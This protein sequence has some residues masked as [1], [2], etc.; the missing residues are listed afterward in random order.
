MLNV[1]VNQA[2]ILLVDYFCLFIMLLAGAFDQLATH[3][4]R[5]HIGA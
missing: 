1:R 2:S 3:R 5:H 4:E